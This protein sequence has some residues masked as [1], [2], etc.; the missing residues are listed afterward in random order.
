MVKVKKIACL[1]CSKQ[2][3][4]IGQFTKV[5]KGQ[6]YSYLH[7]D[8]CLQAFNDKEEKKKKIARQREGFAKRIVVIHELV[9]QGYISKGFWQY[10]ETLRKK[11]EDENF[12]ENLEK[13]YINSEH[14]IKTAKTK[15]EFKDTFSELKYGLAIV[16]NSR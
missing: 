4:D 2:E 13:V 6:G 3:E 5:K 9:H 12:Y 1:E 15:K 8:I 11:S 14:K 7:S 16:L 10:I